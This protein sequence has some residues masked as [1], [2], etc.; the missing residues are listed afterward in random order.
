M[1]AKLLGALCPLEPSFFYPSCALSQPQNLFID[2]LQRHGFSVV[3]LPLDSIRLPCPAPVEELKDNN[4]SLTVLGDLLQVTREFFG[5]D[6]EEKQKHSM[7]LSPF[8]SKTEGT[9]PPL[10]EGY[11]SLF[12]YEFYQVR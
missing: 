10:E 9:E 5:Q 1:Q 2:Q 7:D 6:K 11:V 12:D 3:C 8:S 4:V